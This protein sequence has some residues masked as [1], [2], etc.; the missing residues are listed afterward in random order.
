MGRPAPVDRERGAGDRLPARSAQED[1]ERA[2][3]LDG[4][5]ALVR[6]RREQHVADHRVAADAASFRS[7][8]NLA[9]D[10]RR[11]DIAWAD[12]VAGDAMLGTLERDRL[13]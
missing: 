6:L 11:P 8:V 3:L 5:E 2:K 1:G 13:G 7:V 9:F 4:R 12:G 10:Q